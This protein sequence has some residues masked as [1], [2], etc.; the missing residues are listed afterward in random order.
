MDD[1]K[2][3]QPTY[4]SDEVALRFTLQPYNGRNLRTIVC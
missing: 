3:A 2:L 4:Y 1:L